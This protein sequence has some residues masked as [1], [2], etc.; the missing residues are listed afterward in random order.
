[1][2][3]TI[4]VLLV[5]A[6]VFVALASLPAAAADTEFSDVRE[7]DW[8]CRY[9]REVAKE[10]IMTGTAKGVFSPKSNLTRA[11]VV[12][13]LSRLSGE[14]F[15]DGRHAAPDWIDVKSNKWYTDYVGWASSR[16]IVRGYTDGT[17]RPQSPVTRSE[18][19][20]MTARFARYLGVP[21]P[22]DA[23]ID[24]F[25]D[26]EKIA[27]WAAQDVE[28]LRR[29]GLF[30]GDQSGRFTPNAPIVR[31]EVS[32]VVCRLIDIM[33]KDPMYGKL[34]EAAR[35]FGSA[36]AGRIRAVV[37]AP[38]TLDAESLG[39]AVV[40]CAF[41]L[42]PEKYAL[43]VSENDLAEVRA[44]LSASQSAAPQVSTAFGISIKNVETGETT[45][46]ETV[47]LIFS[48]AP[49]YEKGAKPTISYKIRTDDTCEI[50]SFSD[51]YRSEIVTLPSTVDGFRVVS[52]G[53][54]AFSENKD[55]VELRI[56]EG[57][58]KIGGQAF[59]RCT[60]LKRVTVPD[61]VTKIGR[62]AFYYCSS[63]ETV[64]LP[65]ALERVS[66]YAFYMCTKLR[67]VAV[68]A[69]LED[70]GAFAFNHTAVVS[71][72]FPAG[73]R[74]IGDYSFESTGLTSAKLPESFRH[75]G[76][77]A[78]L[79]CGSLKEIYL[80]SGVSFVGNYVTYRCGA[81]PSVSFGGTESEWT[82]LSFWRPFPDLTVNY[83]GG[84]K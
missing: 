25:T 83:E 2:K 26:G 20:V 6:A 13:I 40:K 78:F 50:V 64:V 56:P 74:R 61:S 79:D 37:G 57:V 22:N 52:I 9:V 81:S 39:I 51:P 15:L 80:P 65:P 18:F 68:P 58:E 35:N 46:V 66:D 76:N 41:G 5:L 62:G 72:P 63:L 77:W 10:G 36:D 49:D 7:K 29:C 48:T 32:A 70:V 67:N 73:F 82:A 8:F 44:K 27:S 14:E 31:S 53:E 17:F 54:G 47:G 4:S 23:K 33:K 45:E 60:S 59:S 42:D 69:S 24:K 3:K 12:T 19:A 43:N 1:M 11:E 34:G 71:F 55:L 16:G 38:D 84:S 30:A 75:L 21:L 28:L